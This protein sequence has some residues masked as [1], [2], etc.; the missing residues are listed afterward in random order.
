ME[1]SAPDTT[2]P[3]IQKPQATII[4]T[5]NTSLMSRNTS[6]TAGIDRRIATSITVDGATFTQ[7]DQVL[8]PAPAHDAFFL[9]AAERSCG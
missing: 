4:K 8:A 6:V 1:P 5:N 2:V 9:R 3:A 7:A